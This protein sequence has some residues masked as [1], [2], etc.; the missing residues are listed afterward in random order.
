[1]KTAVRLGTLI[2]FSVALFGQAPPKDV[3]GWDKIKWGMTVAQA[4]TLYG[5][6][7]QESNG[8]GTSTD[9]TERL[10]IPSLAIG[11]AKMKVSIS[12][13]TKSKLI[14]EVSFAPAD[15]SIT[16]DVAYAHLKDLLTQ[17]Y[18]RPISEEKE[19]GEETV[20]S[21]AMWTFPSTVIRL[22]LIEA[23]RIAFSILGLSYTA[24]DKKSLDKL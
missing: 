2:A 16:R 20:S 13:D 1:M 14:K 22:Y 11:D 7:V 5:A 9:Y 6:Q 21:S 23:K 8:D 15:Q 17:K 10:V 4:R 19:P 24:T 18:G 12:I 3:N